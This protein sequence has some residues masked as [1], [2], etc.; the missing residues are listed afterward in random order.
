MAGLINDPSRPVTPT[1][2][3]PGTPPVASRSIPSLDGLRALSITFVILSHIFIESLQSASPLARGALLLVCNGTLGVNIFFGISGFLITSL[4]LKEL[5]RTRKINLARFYTRRAFRIFPAF[6]CYLLVVL[7]LSAAGLVRESS[8]CWVSAATYLRNYISPVRG[9]WRLVHG[10][11]LVTVGRGAILPGLA[12]LP[13]PARASPGHPV[14]RRLD[15]PI[16]R[17]ARSDL[18]LSAPLE[19][20]HRL[21]D[22]YTGRYPDGRVVGGAPGRRSALPT[23]PRS[24]F[25]VAAPAG[26]GPLPPGRLPL[27]DRSVRRRLP[28]V[29]RLRP[30]SDCHRPGPPLGCRA[31]QHGV[32]PSPE[33]PGC[34]PCWG[35]LVQSL[36]VAA[37]VHS[38]KF[39]VGRPRNRSGGR[40]LLLPCRAPVPNPPGTRPVARAIVLRSPRGE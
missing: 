25:R 1:I 19:D 34:R 12:G 16:P 31:A 5:D 29:V 4:L 24:G 10:P 3:A 11:R 14:G 22:P 40:S 38:W 20:R 6:Y 9:E 39:M 36:F 33:R 21:H 15:C 2:D 30:R 8:T 37:N 18:Y 23:R 27:A 26:R 17:L 32:R 28:N 7:L 13:R 35:H